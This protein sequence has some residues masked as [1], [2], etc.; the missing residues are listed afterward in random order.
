MKLT[1]AMIFYKIISPIR[2]LLLL[3]EIHIIQ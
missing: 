3:A 1:K 2:V